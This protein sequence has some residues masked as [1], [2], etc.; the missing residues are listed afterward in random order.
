MGSERP[1]MFV[2]RKCSE[3]VNH[4][5]ERENVQQQPECVASGLW[6]ACSA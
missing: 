1:L 2:G 6:S 5:M 3:A 4:G